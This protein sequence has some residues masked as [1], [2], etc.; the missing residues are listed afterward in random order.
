M[1]DP[2][3]SLNFASFFIQLLLKDLNQQIFSSNFHKSQ[4]SCFL[5]YLFNAPLVAFN[6][7]MYF[8]VPPPATLI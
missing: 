5:G 3:F 6:F 4:K 7:A 2:P 1:Y 8:G